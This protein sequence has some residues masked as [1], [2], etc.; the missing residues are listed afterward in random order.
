MMTTAAASPNTPQTVATAMTM[1]RFW[2]VFG[3]LDL[4][5]RG[6]EDRGLI[7]DPVAVDEVGSEDVDISE[8][9]SGCSVSCLHRVMV[10]RCMRHHM[11]NRASRTCRQCSRGE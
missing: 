2:V 5:S 3:E 10:S 9:F 11:N 1:V 8:A 4:A 6:V 7:I